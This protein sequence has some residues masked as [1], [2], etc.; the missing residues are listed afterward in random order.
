MREP[1]GAK[2][3]GRG[4]GRIRV[5]WVRA[6]GLESLASGA[7]RLAQVLAV[8]FVEAQVTIVVLAL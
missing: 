4:A 8:A 7:M 5:L 2:G 6:L 1:L 3:A